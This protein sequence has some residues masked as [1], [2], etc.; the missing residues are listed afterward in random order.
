MHKPLQ[1][2]TSKMRN[3][4]H[5]ALL[6]AFGSL[7]AATGAQAQ[8]KG[9]TWSGY[10][11]QGPPILALPPLVTFSSVSAKWVQPSVFCTT[12]NAEVSFWVGLDGW[13]TTTVEQAG[14]VAVCG[15]AAAPLYYK[16]WWEMYAGANSSGA[17]PFDVSPGDTIEAS[18]TYTNGAYVL[19]VTDLT[20]GKS[21]TTTQTC[22][23]SV[24]CYRATAEWIVERPGGGKYPLADFGTATFTNLAWSASSSQSVTGVTMDMVEK[25]TNTPLSNCTASNLFRNFDVTCKWQ[26]AGQ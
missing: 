14:T 12:P 11:L 18:V 25:S 6:F 26:A 15:T 23:S 9:N 19:S 10:I 1:S 7:V 5:A 3:K 4:T 16:A 22:D 13:G 8:E 2:E 24:T 17:K 20:T 21:F